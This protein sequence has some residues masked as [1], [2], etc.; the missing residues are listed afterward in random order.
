MTST[1]ASLSSSSAMVSLTLFG[2]S[3]LFSFLLAFLLRRLFLLLAGVDG[4]SD[5]GGGG[6]GDGGFGDGC[7]FSF[8]VSV[9][10]S[11]QSHIG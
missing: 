5:C 9:C 1:I 11:C 4:G 6:F 3:S 2:V 7:L 8:F 10:G